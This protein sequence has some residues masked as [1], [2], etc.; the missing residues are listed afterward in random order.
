VASFAAVIDEAHAHHTPV[1]GH[2]GETSWI[3]GAR[4]GIDYL[5]HAADWSAAT[6]PA[7]RRPAYANAIQARGPIRKRRHEVTEWI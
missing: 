2:L 7:D 6:L 4:L 5:T 1:I 3:E